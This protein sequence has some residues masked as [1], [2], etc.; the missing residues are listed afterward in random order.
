MHSVSIFYVD[1]EHNSFE[2]TFK[3]CFDLLDSER[4]AR[5]QKS[6]SAKVKEELLYAGAL[7]ETVLK[8]KGLDESKILRM[9]T[10]KPYIE[11]NVD[12][13]FNISHS[14]RFVALA[15]SDEEL[16]F[17]IQKPVSANENLIRRIASEREIKEKSSLINDDFALF[18]AIKESYAK[19][20]GLGIGTDFA[21]VS[22][23][24][25]DR[26]IR[27]FENNVLKA[28]GS[29]IDVFDG[30]GAALCAGEAF[31]IDTIKEIIF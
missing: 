18:W 31:K 10:G 6:R 11:G 2:E 29:I 27:Y 22:F 25:C 12:F 7:L 14:G 5:I 15:F 4:K 1:T 21:G 17:D 16:G 19:Y 20:T 13:H 9:E 28:Y 30:Y 24:L 23:E 8:E 3:N 26:E